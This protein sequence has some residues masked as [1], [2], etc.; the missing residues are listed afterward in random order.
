MRSA[1]E[2]DE[3]IERIAINPDAELHRKRTNKALNDAK[4]E[5]Q[6]FA[7][8]MKQQDPNISFKDTASSQQATAGISTAVPSPVVQLQQQQQPSDQGSAVPS[9]QAQ[10]G[11]DSS[12]LRPAK[13]VKISQEQADQPETAATSSIHEIKSSQCQQPMEG[14]AA[15]QG[16]QVLQVPHDGSLDDGEDSFTG[17]KRSDKAAH[18]SMDERSEME[19][20]FA[21]AGISQPST[22]SSGGRGTA[23]RDGQVTYAQ[24]VSLSLDPN[25]FTAPGPI[26]QYTSDLYGPDDPRFHG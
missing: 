10:M 6:K 9:T 13:R 8:R 3:W 24:G 18:R 22:I 7:Q 21:S 19:P 12:P 15:N 14:Q 4:N 23:G 17:H 16:Q 1:F 20:G 2:S 11:S 26:Q 25:P 5:K